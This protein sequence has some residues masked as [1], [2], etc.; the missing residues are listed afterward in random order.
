MILLKTP[1]EIE[2]LRIAGRWAAR[3][4]R[5]LGHMVRPG[6]RIVELNEYADR[7]LKEHGLEPVFKGYRPSFAT[8]P[9][10]GHICVSVNEEVVHGI[11]TRNRVLQAGDVVSIDVGVRY[12]GYVGDTAAT[13][14]V[15]PVAPDRERLIRVTREALRRAIRVARAGARLGDIG[16]TIAHYV[17]EEEGLEVVRQYVGH[18]VGREMHEDPAVPNY[19]RPGRGM[20]LKPGLVIAIEPMVVLGKAATRVLDDGWTVVT[21]DGSCAAH[22][23]HTIAIT[24]EKTIILTDPNGPSA[25]DGL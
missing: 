9:F 12:D 17:E 14:P 1:D 4:L 18:G 23:E 19:G 24:E 25:V 2:K 7:F 13:F 10:P 6:L 15:G 16:H 3:L 5:D 8:T 22:F 11:P 21:R 20:I